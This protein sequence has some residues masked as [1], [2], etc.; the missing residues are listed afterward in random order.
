M[1]LWIQSKEFPVYEVSSD[2]RVRNS[3]TGRIMRTA[4]NSKGYPHVCLH[5]NNVQH[6]RAVH[7]L[8]ADAFYDGD[9][10]GLDVNHIDGDKTNNHVYNL[11]WCTR[12]QNLQH[13]YE[14]GLKPPL[15]RTKVRVVETGKVYG[16]LTDCAKAIDG[17]RCQ[18]RRC[19]DGKEHSCQGY[20]FELV[21]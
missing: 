21:N 18:I 2:G 16:S 1:E 6:T 15:R 19:L 11:E 10:E 17:D 9:H 20:H 7:R 14:T 5:E 4:A 13:A 8:V 12:Q 3:K